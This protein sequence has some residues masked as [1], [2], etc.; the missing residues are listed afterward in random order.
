[1]IS[2]SELEK[3]V[4]NL[5]GA[6]VLVVGDLMLDTYMVGDA[7]RISPE[8]P[9]PVVKLEKRED[10]LGGAANTAMNIAALGGEPIILGVIGKDEAGKR[11]QN[12]LET[13]GLKVLGIFL[14]DDMPTI[15]KTRIV[16]GNQQIVRV[17]NE[18]FLHWPDNITEYSHVAIDQLLPEVDAVAVSDYAKGCLTGN[19]MTKLNDVARMHNVPILVDPKPVNAG[20]FKGCDLLKPNKKEATELSGIEILDDASCNKAAAIIMNEFSPRALLITRGSDGMDLH[21]DGQKPVRIAA[22]ISQVF[23]VSGAGDTVLAMLSMA[24]AKNVDPEIACELAS[25]AAG[26]AVR[27]P[28]TSVVTADEVVEAIAMS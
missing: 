3:T 9:V 1:M 5:A 24:Y 11:F 19:L 14:H 23:D 7:A 8:A 20:L 17:D 12:L 18:G 15:Q 16:A 10:R 27:K 2:G 21:R 22:H 13:N 6:K 25:Y 26:I 4:V 28:G